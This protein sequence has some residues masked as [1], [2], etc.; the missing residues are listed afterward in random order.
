M[1]EEPIR[2]YDD[3]AGCAALARDLELPI[4]LGENFDGPG[5]MVQA[6]RAVP[7]IW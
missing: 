1:L 4:Q 5:Q 6:L 2:L 7:A 3:L